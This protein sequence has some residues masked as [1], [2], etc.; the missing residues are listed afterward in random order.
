MEQGELLGKTWGLCPTK[1]MFDESEVMH[2]TVVN[3]MPEFAMMGGAC[4]VAQMEGALCVTSRL[5]MADQMDL[6]ALQKAQLM[7]MIF[8][9]FKHKAEARDE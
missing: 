2:G 1:G 6:S 5:A 7:Q 3:E 4:H 9:W 8:M